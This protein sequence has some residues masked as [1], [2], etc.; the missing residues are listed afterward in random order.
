MAKTKYN[1]DQCSK[2]HEA[3]PSTK[4]GKNCFCSPECIS[5]FQKESFKGSNNP[6]YRG[7][8]IGNSFCECGNKKD[9]RAK[10]CSSCAKTSTPLGQPKKKSVTPELLEV[11]KNSKDHVEISNKTGLNRKTVS[12]ILSENPDIDQS[13]LRE[14]DRPNGYDIFTKHSK[15]NRNSKVR[16]TVIENN[17]IEYICHTCGLPPEWQGK[18][19]SLDMDHINGDSKDDRLE[20]L[21]FLCP[22]CHR[23]TETNGF[24][25]MFHRKKVGD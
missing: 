9:Y 1:C 6:N 16:P 25:P 8:E 11:I 22:N 19:L 7:V 13:H 5:L 20:N 4:K 2:E 3:Y 14:R 17:L 10:K 15:R 21:R 23:Q 12:R 24:N 18:P